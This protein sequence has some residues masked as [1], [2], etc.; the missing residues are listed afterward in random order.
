MELTEKMVAREEKFAGH[1]VTLHVDAITLPNGKS[2][3]REVVTHPG[4]VGILPLHE[5]GTVTVVRQFR[6]PF[7]R[8][9]T[10]IPAG[11]LD[12]GEAHRVCALRE[13]EEEVGLV[14][15]KLT[16]LG[17]HLA[18]PGFCNE[19]LH[20]YLAQGLC[21]VPRHPD[22]DEFLEVFRVPL[23]TLVEQAMD[24]TLEDA[25]TV[26]AVLKT[27]VLLGI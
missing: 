14:P 26:L 5:D 7:E 24:G 16:Y 15:E 21:E 9:V 23:T 8:V 18:S 13:L 11:K 20:L 22:E 2:A 6:Y 3:T 1:I 17:V 19:V 10:E 25:K 27:K 12:A 4:G